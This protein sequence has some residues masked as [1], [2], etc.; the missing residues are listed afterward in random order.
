[1]LTFRP[2]CHCE[3]RSDDAISFGPL[4]IASVAMTPVRGHQAKEPER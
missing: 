2:R 3:E 1:M 4:E